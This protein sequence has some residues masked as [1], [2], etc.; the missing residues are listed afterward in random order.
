MLL[1]QR[2]A[3]FAQ[4]LGGTARARVSLDRLK[5]VFSVTLYLQNYKQ[6]I[7]EEAGLGKTMNSVLER[8][9]VHTGLQLRRGCR[10]LTP[11]ARDST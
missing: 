6:E 9:L 8:Q 3:P 11:A 4:V 7:Q 10:S 2:E 5:L 1:A